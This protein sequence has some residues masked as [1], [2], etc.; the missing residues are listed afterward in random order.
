MGVPV[1]S[2]A[3][4]ECYLT[5][6]GQLRR[7]LEIKEAINLEERQRTAHRD[8]RKYSQFCRG[9]ER[10]AEPLSRE[11]ILNRSKRAD[12]VIERNGR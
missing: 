9:H 10:D 5:K 6:I 11:S 3:V 7:V 8:H 2:V 4:G 1:E 12:E